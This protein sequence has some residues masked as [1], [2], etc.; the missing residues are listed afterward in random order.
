MTNQLQI[1]A[2][3]DGETYIGAIGDKNGDVYHLV[4]LAGDNDP[5]LHSVQLEW[6]KS[7]GGDLPNKLESAMLFAHAKGEFKPDWYWTSETFIDPYD[8]KDD[9]WAWCQDFGTGR[10]RSYHKNTKLRARSVRRVPVEVT[11]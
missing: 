11:K 1:P 8:P 4:L 3:A 6:A 9:G 5:A 7:I 2:L 10:Q